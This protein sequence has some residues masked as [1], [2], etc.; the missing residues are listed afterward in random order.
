MQPFKKGKYSAMAETSL[1][2]IVNTDSCVCVS[3]YIS[4]ADYKNFVNLSTHYYRRLYNCHSQTVSAPHYLFHSL[5]QMQMHVFQLSLITCLLR[6]VRTAAAYFHKGRP[7]NRIPDLS[8]FPYF[9][10]ST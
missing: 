9:H 2:L 5:F 10:I 3:V 6:S 1:V 4:V 7:G 8:L